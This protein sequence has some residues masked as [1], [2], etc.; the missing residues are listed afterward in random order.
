M[1]GCHSV[2]DR[3][4]L[5]SRVAPPTRIMATMRAA[6]AASQMRSA[7]SCLARAGA[8]SCRA[9]ALWA[10]V[11]VIA[12]LIAGPRPRLN[13][14][15]PAPSPQR[16]LVLGGMRAPCRDAFTR[17]ECEGGWRAEKR[18]ILMAR[19]LR[20]AGAFRR[21]NHGG[22]RQ[23]ALLSSGP[24]RIECAD[25]SVSQLL[26]GTPSGPGG[27]SD[28]ARVPRCDEARR[29]RTSSRLHDAS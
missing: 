10:R 1:I 3:P 19:A 28:A 16:C 9:A 18:K 22:F 7:R 17:P 12:G 27:S 11:E 24:S 20:H 23:R 5:V 14:Q 21:A 2:M 13:L 15:P 26:A 6:I 25:R 29:R 8:L 4:E